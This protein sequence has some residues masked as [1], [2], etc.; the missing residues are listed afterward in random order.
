MRRISK[1]T[2]NSILELIDNGLSSHKIAAQLG[3]HHATVNRVRA[4]ARPDAQKSQ[5]GRPAKLTATDKRMLVRRITSGKADNAVQLT[6]QLSDITNKK[7][8]AQTVRRGLKE[9]GLKAV[10]KKKAATFA[11]AHPPAPRVRLAAPALDRGG[12]EARRLVR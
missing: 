10:H 6:R 9:E 8:S 3:V 2:R 7:V 4:E 11:K 5:G 12:L 1:D